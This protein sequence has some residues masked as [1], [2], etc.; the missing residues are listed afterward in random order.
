M[1]WLSSRS[2]YVRLLIMGPTLQTHV[3]GAPFNRDSLG[4]SM[5]FSRSCVAFLVSNAVTGHISKRHGKG[6]TGLVCTLVTW[7]DIPAAGPCAISFLRAAADHRFVCLDG[8]LGFSVGVSR[9]LCRDVDDEAFC[10]ILP[11]SWAISTS[12]RILPI[13]SQRCLALP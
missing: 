13:P 4:A 6:E 12:V 8:F 1:T 11:R 7:F 2:P 9:C 5:V 3:Q 10:L